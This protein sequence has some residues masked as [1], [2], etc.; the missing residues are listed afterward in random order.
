MLREVNL[1]IDSISSKNTRD[2]YEYHL[3]SFEKWLG[4]KP[5]SLLDVS[6]AVVTQKII[7]YLVSMRDKELSYG[8]R[9]I[10]T[11]AIKHYYDMN[12]VVL[13]W[14]K[15]RRFLEVTSANN[16]RGYTH[17]EISKLL[18]LADVK[19]RA[20]ILMY[21]STGM[22]REALTSLKLEDMEYI[23]D[24]QLYKI[25]LYRKTQHE[26]ITFTTPEAAKAINFFLQNRELRRRNTKEDFYFH[27]VNPDSITERLRFLSVECGLN[28]PA[29]EQVQ[30]NKAHRHQIPSVHGFR[31][32][33]ITQMVKAKVDVEIAK[34]LTDHTIGV[35]A[36]YVNYSEDDLLQE[37][38]KAVD[39]LTINEENRLKIRVQDLTSKT[40]SNEYI[41]RARL[42]EKDDQVQKLM[43]KQEQFEQ[44]IQSLIDSGQLRPD[45]VHQ[46]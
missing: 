27:N 22:R 30:H 25:R 8:Y 12:D 45:T 46:Y 28:H 2:Q 31:K 34:L 11:S 43:K 24:Y 29:T 21:A 44:L 7:Q 6:P 10:A 35:R 3:K 4:T 40:E 32:F 19:Y 38:L 37:Y 39:T 13:N 17:E 18:S 23:K 20:I 26:H 16:L 42:Q 15:I 36:K 41:I 14:K 1:F 9:G 33:A 5:E